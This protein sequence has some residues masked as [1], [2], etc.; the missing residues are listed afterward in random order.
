[1]TA[2]A[3][4]VPAVSPALSIPDFIAHWQGH[5]ALTRRVIEAFPDDQ[6]FTFSLG[7]MR[8]FG[9]QATEIHLVDAMTVTAMRTGEWPE[10]GGPRSHRHR[11]RLLKRARRSPGRWPP[12]SR[13]WPPPRPPRSPTT[14]LRQFGQPSR[15][16]N[17]P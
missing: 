2:P 10:P 9:A 7:G 6:L 4:S 14:L 17:R 12:R 11:A 15:R 5:R 8:P 13:A 1:M 3:A 16:R